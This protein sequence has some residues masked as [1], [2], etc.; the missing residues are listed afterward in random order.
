MLWLCKR[1]KNCI[2]KGS[3]FLSQYL[4]PSSRSD[5]PPGYHEINQTAKLI[6]GRCLVELYLFQKGHFL[7]TLSAQRFRDRE[8]LQYVMEVLQI[9]FNTYYT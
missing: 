4:F 3:L 1:Q 5:Q 6:E 7:I 2:L 8:S 9:Y